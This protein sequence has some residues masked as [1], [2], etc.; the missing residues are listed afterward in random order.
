MSPPPF[1]PTVLHTTLAALQAQLALVFPANEFIQVV[2][3]PKITPGAWKELTRRTP[4]IGLGWD[5][6]APE[7][8][9]SRRLIGDT[10]WS[11][12]L[13]VRNQAGPTP[14]FLGDAL[15]PGLF[16]LV[17]AAAAV[18]HGHTI[19]G[20]GTAFVTAINNTIGMDWDM[21][22][23]VLACLSVKVGATLPTA[24]D[25][26]ADT[27]AGILQ[28]MGITWTFPHDPSVTVVTDE[29]ETHRHRHHEEHA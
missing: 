16:D 20:V 3:P 27:G 8:P 18:L 19:W 9:S 25:L 11:I 14:R 6:F 22:D 15:G 2:L 17:S 23:L 7:S 5:A 1:V 26:V 28:E 13:V 21:E 12:F 24:A 10:T 4:M 29:T